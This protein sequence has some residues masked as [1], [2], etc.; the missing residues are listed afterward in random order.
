[1]TGLGARLW[2]A[3]VTVELLTAVSTWFIASVVGPRLF[4]TH[5]AG[6]GETLPPTIAAHAEQAFR[7]ANLLALLFGFLAA[8]VL[9]LVVIL[10]VTRRFG[11]SAETLSAAATRIAG[12]AY[13]TRVTPPRLG[14]EF[15]S[16][17]GALNRMAA[18]LETV[19]S[20]RRRLL[21][22]LAHEVRTP[23]TVI[24]GYLEGLQDGVVAPDPATFEMLRTQTA[25]LARLSE[26]IGAISQAEEGQ[27]DLQT[28]RV[29]PADL[30][31]DAIAAASRSYSDRD[32]RLRGDITPA[33][34]AVPVDRQRIE[35]VLTNLLA[36]ALRHSRPGGEV[37]VTAHRGTRRTVEIAVHDAGGGI[38]AEH[39]P[40]IFERFYRV[41]TARD[42]GHGGTG[43]GLAISKA[44]V[45]AHGG[46]V[47][48]HSA[49]PDRGATFTVVLPC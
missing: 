39:L 6:E 2:A 26:D 30:V 49:G 35:Q 19:E 41:D 42:R 48:A 11:R 8:F 25:R 16:L 29:A 7:S 3:L 24:D 32:L 37:L 13:G 1:M 28:E 10:T 43:I 38:A 46:Q 5:L 9:S 31:S 23:I 12:G 18:Q 47:R 45:E 27:L 44:I 20:T 21:A 14:R 33:L 15:D 22:D 17:A 40:H 4:R 36:N 34:P